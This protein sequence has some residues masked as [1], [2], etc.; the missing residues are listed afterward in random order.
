VHCL[1]NKGGG[2]KGK[3]RFVL[4][5]FFTKGRGEN[6]ADSF[7]G[8]DREQSKSFSQ[9]M[10]HRNTDE[11]PAQE[12]KNPGPLS[13]RGTNFFAQKKARS[14]SKRKENSAKA[15]SSTSK[16]LEGVSNHSHKGN[17]FRHLSLLKKKGGDDPPTTAE[18]RL[19]ARLL[20]TP[21]PG[22]PFNKIREG[23]K[24]EKMRTR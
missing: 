9:E 16:H 4:Y 18:G 5:F 6:Q 7:Q 12:G 21:P 10:L 13:S 1:A 14:F 23:K 3:G 24:K 11:S 15:P 2:G 22:R 17:A 20:T 8:P 19:E